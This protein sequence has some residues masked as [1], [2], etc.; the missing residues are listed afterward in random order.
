MAKVFVSLILAAWVCGIALLA[1]QNGS[2]VSLYFFNL[3]SIQIP[4]GI[5]LAFCAAAGMVG[6]A[7]VL[8]LFQSRRVSPSLRDREDFE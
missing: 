8:P 6:M 7:I 1:A 2:P 5:A 3:Q 4:V